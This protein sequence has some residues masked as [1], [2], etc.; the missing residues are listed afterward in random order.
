M[1]S[2][3]DLRF[4]AQSHDKLE[5]LAVFPSND[6]GKSFGYSSVTASLLPATEK[7][8]WACDLALNIYTDLYLQEDVSC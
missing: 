8:I 2:D 1:R 4:L 3:S 6:H 5:V 7:W